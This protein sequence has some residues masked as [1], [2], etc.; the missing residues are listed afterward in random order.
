MFRLRLLGARSLW[1]WASV[2]VL[3]FLL[4]MFTGYLTVASA[5]VPWM[6]VLGL[7]RNIILTDPFRARAA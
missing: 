7:E 6:Y 5:S 2:S 1:Y 4:A 3:V